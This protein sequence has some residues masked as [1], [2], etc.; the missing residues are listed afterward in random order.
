MAGGVKV[1]RFG[2][3]EVDNATA[4]DASGSMDVGDAVNRGRSWESEPASASIVTVAVCWR[5]SRTIGG[6]AVESR[7]FWETREATAR[8]RPVA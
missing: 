2:A 8:E 5:V 3:I 1:M 7:A 4:D 6:E